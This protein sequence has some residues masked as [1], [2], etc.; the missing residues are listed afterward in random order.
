MYCGRCGKQL[1]EE[2]HFCPQCG[3]KK[4]VVNQGS[5][6]DTNEENIVSVDNNNEEIEEVLK[7]ED[8]IFFNNLK[9][10]LEKDGINKEII[11]N[12]I[13]SNLNY[14]SEISNNSSN[15]VITHKIKNKRILLIA[16]GVAV[17]AIILF[18]SFKISFGGNKEYKDV[19]K[20]FCEALEDCDANELLD[21]MP[22]EITNSGSTFYIQYMKTFLTSI[23]EEI[24]EE[25]NVSY[26]IKNSIVYS[27]DKSNEL[28]TKLLDYADNFDFKFSDLEDAAYIECDIIFKYDDKKNI[29]T[30]NFELIKVNK[31]WYIIGM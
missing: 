25:F 24:G 7:E 30:V 26:K 21:C 13:T 5:S 1:E 28:D 15:E 6:I 20:D 17:L 22:K 31:V 3:Q 8:I 10:N 4:E 18:I 11:Y 16:G 19:I 12:S 9:T 2:M 14:R 23:V 27:K 29:Q